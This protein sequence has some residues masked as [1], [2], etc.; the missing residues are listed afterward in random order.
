MPGPTLLVDLAP[1]EL[2]PARQ[3]VR[4][5]ELAERLTR[6]GSFT[7]GD[8][9]RGPP[10]ETG[11]DLLEVGQVVAEWAPP[12]APGLD[13]DAADALGE[14]VAET[15]VATVRP[16]LLGASPEVA[17]VVTR[18]D[19]VTLTIDANGA[20]TTELVAFARAYAARAQNAGG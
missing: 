15:L 4:A 18:L 19:G 8:V 2:D 17:R 9:R 1:P 6:S 11:V 16:W 7:V 13:E 10:D 14:R 3:C 12:P 5:G 20:S